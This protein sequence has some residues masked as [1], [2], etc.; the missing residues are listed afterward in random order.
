MYS[1]YLLWLDRSDPA[2]H[3]RNASKGI[4]FP[5]ER[6]EIAILFRVPNELFIKVWVWTHFVMFLMKKV[7]KFEGSLL[8]LF[9][10]VFSMSDSLS[11]HRCE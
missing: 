6:L 5:N 7:V 2:I 1:L 9:L 11:G 3:I 4:E 10:N 8:T